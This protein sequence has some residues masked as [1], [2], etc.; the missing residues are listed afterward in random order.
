MYMSRNN[1]GQ[2]N[3][4]V[5]LTEAQFQEEQ[6][7]QAQQNKC[8]GCGAGMKFDIATGGLKCNHC[9]SVQEFNDNELV[10]RRAITDDLINKHEKWDEARVLRCANCG[11]TE[12][13]NRTDISL[14]CAFCGSAKIT[15]V[16]DLPGIKPDSVIPFQITPETAHQ[17]FRKWI[18]GKFFAPSRFKKADVKEHMN[19]IYTPCWSFS[20]RTENFYN[21]T[22]GRTV[23]VHHH[24]RGGMHG[25]G[26]HGGHTET[27]IHWFRV[28]GVMNKHYTDVFFQSGSRISNINF[29]RL[30]PYNLKQ[31]KVYRQEYLSG[32]IAEHYSKTLENCLNEFSQFVKSDI[33]RD[34]LRKHGADQ[35]SHLNIQTTFHDRHFNYVLLP[36][37]VSNYT[38]KNKLYNFYV[39]GATGNIVGRYPKSI[40]KI[41]VIVLG[42]IAIVAGAVT[43]L[44]FSGM[45]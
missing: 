40:M 19:K 26:S 36:V 23:T 10:Q 41:G 32:I 45:I 4:E 14:G 6:K 39:N 5:A 17:R 21:G 34:I 18:K 11:A 25:R 28:S 7:L 16:E 13:V 20:S 22:L 8:T 43:G 12:V 29:N 37:Y 30:K 9:G 1:N 44:W 38:Y 42:V 15:A 24:H 27:R 35:V 31:V 2:M 33:R 3:E